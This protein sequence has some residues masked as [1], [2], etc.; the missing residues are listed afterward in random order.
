[1]DS[2][3]AGNGRPGCAMRSISKSRT[4]LSAFANAVSRIATPAITIV[5]G[6]LGRPVAHHAP[7]TTPATDRS[8][9]SHRISARTE[10][11]FLPNRILVQRFVLPND[12]VAREPRA[13]V[14]RGVAAHCLPALAVGENLDR[15]G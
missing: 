10:A 1:M 3:P 5:S 4:S 15:R 8:A 2:V 11:M 7:S 13:G 6:W 9:F 14:G 12:V